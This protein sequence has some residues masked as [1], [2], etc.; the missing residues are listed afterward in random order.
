MITVNVRIR[1]DSPKPL[2][3]SFP[4]LTLQVTTKQAPN[5]F[6]TIDL[7]F[8]VSD[9]VKAILEEFE[10]N[11]EYHPVKVVYRSKPHQ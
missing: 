7:L 6:F 11:A 8:I 10:V 5:D 2:R 9:R 4:K 3:K 1:Y